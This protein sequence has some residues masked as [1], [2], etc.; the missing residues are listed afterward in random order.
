MST[1]I[2]RMMKNS[3]IKDSAMIGDSL[4]FGNKDMIT[5]SVPMLNVAASGRVDGGIKP[6][7]LTIAGPSKHFKT[8]FALILASAFQKKHP[9]GIILFYDSEFG[10]PQ[11]Y[12]QAAGIDMSRVFHTPITDIEQLRFDI[13]Q[14]INGFEK[15]DNVFI[16]IDS[17]GNLASKKE[18][19]DALDGKSVADMTR[20]RTLKS[21]WRM[22]TPHLS[23]KDIPLV[24]VNH[25]YKTME[26]YSK[27]VVSGG[28]GGV[29]SSDTIWIVGRAQEKDKASDKEISGY[30]FTINIEKS[31]YVKEKSKIP[32]V[33]NFEGGIVKWSGLL[34]VAM[35]GGY[36]RKP[37]AGWYEV[38]NPSTGEILVDKLYREKELNRAGDVWK[39]MLEKTDLANF[40]EKKYTVANGTLIQDD[41]I[42][43]SEQ[44]N[45]AE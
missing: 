41:E 18:V 2:E 14:Q 10:S 20:A 37:K 43:Q 6:G 27:D 7:L 42:E 19:D 22:V 26:M 16:L 33:V 21:L 24:N 29:Y 39:M 23:L 45:D 40:I 13:M 11:T 34:D 38:V 15:K 17:I 36:V 1:L 31:R 5:T 35:E 32:I 30:K 4:V 9:D 25:T 12:L 3:T 44:E 8:A 28:T